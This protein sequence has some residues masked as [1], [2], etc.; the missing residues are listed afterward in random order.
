MAAAG[1]PAAKRPKK[2]PEKLRIA[3]ICSSNMNR[4]M[5]G[6]KVLTAAGFNVS[7]YGTGTQV[8]LPGPS[9]DKPNVY[10]FGTPYSEILADLKSQDEQLYIRNRMVD[11]LE[12]NVG[13]KTAP[14]RWQDELIAKFDIVITFEERVYDAVVDEFQVRQDAVDNPLDGPPVHCINIETKDTPE[15]SEKNVKKALMLCQR[16]RDILP[17]LERAR[18]PARRSPQPHANTRVGTLIADTAL[19]GPAAGERG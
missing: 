10:D 9:K 1:G 4:S 14:E 5:E 13:I 15:E 8:K 3:S 18:P 11:L 19:L 2:E 12:R 17:L 16:V 6:H 7:S